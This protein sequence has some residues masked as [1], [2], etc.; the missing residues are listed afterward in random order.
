MKEDLPE[1]VEP[2]KELVK[3]YEAMSTATTIA[4]MRN[5]A[6]EFLTKTERIQNL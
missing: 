5:A 6:K 3:D 2:Q 4:Q 1:E